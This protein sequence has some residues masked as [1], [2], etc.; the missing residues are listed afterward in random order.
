MCT[1]ER[2]KERRKESGFIIILNQ[3]VDFSIMTSLIRLEIPLN[4][5]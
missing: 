5:L 2:E 3:A 4:L 1:E